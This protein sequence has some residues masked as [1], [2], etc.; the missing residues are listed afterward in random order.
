MATTDTREHLQDLLEEFDA[1]M[2]VTRTPAA[3]HA[4]PMAVA[5]LEPDSDVYLVTSIDSPKIAEIEANPEATL[6]FQSSSRYATLYGHIGIVRD[7][8]K[9]DALWKE[10][11]KI[12]FPKGKSDPAITLL[13]FTA[14]NG[15]YWDNAGANGLKFAFD[16]AKAYVKG[17]TPNRDDDPKQHSRVRL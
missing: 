5:E 6:T 17:E 10:A 11:W 14:E 12:W 9:I 2:L 13:K 3:M 1:A 16:A 15:E 4:R 7:R 8:A